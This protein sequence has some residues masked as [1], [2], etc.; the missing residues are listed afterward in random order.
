MR[1]FTLRE[2]AERIAE[3]DP[4]LTTDYVSRQ[5]RYFVLRR[6]IHPLGQRGSGKTAA[7]LIDDN[8]LCRGRIGTECVRIGLP[9]AQVEAAFGCLDN[10][11]GRVRKIGEEPP[12]KHRGR[13]F[14]GVLDAIREGE[15]WAFVLWIAPFEGK[16]PGVLDVSGGFYPFDEV[17][18]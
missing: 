3:H 15:L 18:L 11:K 13:G 9:P 7:W 2:G 14:S 8:R 6:L 16:N 1:L 5:F 12:S 10:L 17:R 4:T